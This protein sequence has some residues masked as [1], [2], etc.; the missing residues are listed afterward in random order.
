ML[1]LQLGDQIAGS[2]ADEGEE[3]AVLRAAVGGEP[4]GSM[5]AVID[6][7]DGCRHL[8][9]GD[10]GQDA[11]DRIDGVN[12]KRVVFPVREYGEIRAFAIESHAVNDVDAVVANIAVFLRGD[13]L[14]DL[15]MEIEDH[16]PAVLLGAD[17]AAAFTAGRVQPDWRRS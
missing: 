16:G 13:L 7:E 11:G 5:I 10:I 8:G 1:Q 6:A 14:D 3:R 12:C 17:H 4:V 15:A 9:E 2:L